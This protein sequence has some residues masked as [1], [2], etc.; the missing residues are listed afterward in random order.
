MLLPSKNG[1]YLVYNE[2]IKRA[3]G[4]NIGDSVHVTLERDTK[5]RELII[6]SYIEKRLESSNVLEV[7]LKQPNYLK[8]EQINYIEI[9]K[10]D[11]TKENRLVAL[12]KR[13]SDE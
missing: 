8:R 9:A 1:H 2:F 12:I 11:E 6:P 7:F 10:K 4:K 13:L 5:K 3:V